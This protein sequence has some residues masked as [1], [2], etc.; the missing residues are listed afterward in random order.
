MLSGKKYPFDV[1]SLRLYD[2]VAPRTAFSYYDSLL[3]ILN[4]QIPGE[5]RLSER[6][7]KYSAQFIIPAEKVDAVFQAAITE[8]RSRVKEHI[9]L[10][11]NES[12]D[13][14]YVTGKPWS[15]YNWYK[16]NAHSLIQINTD[17]PIYIE[18]AIDLAC[19]EGYPGHHVFNAMLEKS[20]VDER[21]WN[22]YMVYPL[23][24]PQ[25][26]IA[27]GSANYGIDI[28]FNPEERLAFERDI[29]FPL[30][31]LDE[32]KVEEYYTI[33]SLRKGLKSAGI[34]IARSYLNMEVDS[35][36]AIELL[37]KYLQYTPSRAQ[38]RLS[39][40]DRYRSYIINYSL[41]E[42]FVRRNI[43]DDNDSQNDKWEKFNIILTTPRSA[44]T[45]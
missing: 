34:D 27:E 10:P 23:F 4:K 42:E 36:T 8:A 12:F 43:E 40:Y 11:E 29:L 38:Q 28:A 9:E 2:V 31:G 1:E 13:L 24:S 22:E 5:G 17:F 15:A 39:F 45:L 3:D 6:Y 25:S 14:E 41:G 16:G 33:Q 20:L 37:V 32:S 18:R 26:F 7:T 35:E 19:H 44:S 30:A 21:N